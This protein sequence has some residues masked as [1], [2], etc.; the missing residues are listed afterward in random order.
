MQGRPSNLSG[1]PARTATNGVR[2]SAGAESTTLRPGAMLGRYELV[3]RLARGVT[4]EIW[5]AKG[6]SEKAV[7]LKALR[8]DVQQTAELL[9]AFSREAVIAGRLHHPNIVELHD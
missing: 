8:L 5:L 4:T 7:A 6:R 2:T 1:K 3:L 9:R